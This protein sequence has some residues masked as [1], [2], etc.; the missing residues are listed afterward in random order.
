MDP[1]GYWSQAEE[2]QLQVKDYLF[3]KLGPESEYSIAIAFLLSKNYVWQTRNNEAR[4]L[5]Y[6]VLE[7]AKQLYGPKHPTTLQIMDTLG[8]TCILGS[9]YREAYRLHQEVIESLSKLEGSSFAIS[10]MKR[11]LIC[12]DKHMRECKKHWGPTHE[13]TLETKDN[14]AGI[15]GFMGEQHLPLAL[16]MSEEVTLIRKETLGH[17][18]PLTLKSTLTVAKI[19]TAMNQFEEAEQIFLEGLPIAKRNLGENHLGTLTART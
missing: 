8:A 15:W 12:N 16:Q 1:F 10:S 6:Q 4:V 14:L 5:Q 19:K 17:E 11:R 3:T 7:S 13:K 9:R 2:L 18:H